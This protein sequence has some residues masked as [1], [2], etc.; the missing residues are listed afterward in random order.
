MFGTTDKHNKNNC[1]VNVNIWLKL[2]DGQKL[3]VANFIVKL[4][5]SKYL[6]VI[7]TAAKS[8]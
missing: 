6:P 3:I 7:V 4:I 5:L 1:I 2:N 8:L